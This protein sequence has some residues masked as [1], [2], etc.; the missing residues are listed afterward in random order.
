MLF[1]SVEFLVFF[2]VVYGLYLV[3]QH[4]QQNWMLLAA[5]YLFYGWW[6]WRFLTLIWLST[7]VD[8][9]VARAMDDAPTP[10]R[11]RRMLAVSLLFNLGLLGTFKYAGFFARS[12]MDA[13][14]SIGYSVDL[15]FAELVLSLIHISSPR[16]CS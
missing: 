12:F 4:R 15:R 8:W 7:T 13:F 6:D 3:L 10:Q 16:D 2:V 11:K 9:L 1:N 14:A 5:S